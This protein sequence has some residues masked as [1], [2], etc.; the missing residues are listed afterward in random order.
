MKSFAEYNSPD[1]PENVNVVVTVNTFVDPIQRAWLTFDNVLKQEGSPVF[2]I[3]ND[4][5]LLNQ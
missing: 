1:M 2:P 3:A 5:P 4:N